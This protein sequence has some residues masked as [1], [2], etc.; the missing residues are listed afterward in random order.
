[1]APSPEIG[2]GM[3][4]YGLAGRLFHAPFIDAV[5][6]VRIRA[7]A[8][9]HPERR[10]QASNEHPDAAIVGSVDAL[11]DHPDVEVVVIV[12]TNRSHAPIGTQ[13][14]AAGRHVVV[15]KP[16]AMT[17]AEAEALI[18]AGE[19]AGRI[20]S[21]YQNRRWDG[22]FLTVRSLVDASAF[23]TID[24]LEAR[25]E[26]WSAVGP[27]WRE[28]AEE[29]GGPH[30]DLGAHLVDQSLVLFGDAVR[31]FAQIDSRRPGS[32]VE[33]STFMTI[34]HADG[35]RSRL[36]TSLI[37]R[38]TGPR[39]RVRGLDGEY[40]KEDLDPQERQL[41]DGLRPDDPGF[42]E[43]PEERWG[44]LEAGGSST[45]VPTQRGDYRRYYEL[46]RDAVRGLGERPVDPADS[47]RGLRVLEA[48]ERSARSGAVEAISGGSR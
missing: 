3:V 40:V 36:W 44:R 23:G 13:A 16:I 24:S 21:V 47:V 11:I 26:R 10:A 1:V 33:D 8:T 42:G 46:L 15:D 7:I 6:G 17:T 29:A 25:F 20:L 27:E 19:R 43:E 32:R 39:I 4:G 38:R 12:T 41:L 14:L 30:R 31:V 28:T 37:A 34:D 45:P 35:T 9:S 5:D 18:E 2:I 22:D 48:A